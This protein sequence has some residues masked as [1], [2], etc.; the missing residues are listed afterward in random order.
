M[1]DQL[2][3]LLTD[4][5]GELI[6]ANTL[7]IAE[8]LRTSEDGKL[9][10]SLSTKLTLV[11]SRLYAGTS[12]SFARKWK[13]EV[14]ASVEVEDPKQPGLK[15]KDE[16]PTVTITTPDGASTKPMPLGKF[17]RAVEKVRAEKAKDA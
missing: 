1:T 3:K 6:D 15:F 12:L 7:T 4:Q 2:N 13:S 14:E 11:G 9:T 17:K 8:E 16:E 10:I 5:V